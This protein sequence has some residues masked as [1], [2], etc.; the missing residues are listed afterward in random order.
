MTELL[1]ATAIAPARLQS[2]VTVTRRAGAFG[3]SEHADNGHEMDASSDE[4]S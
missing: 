4:G 2:Y 1:P 3:R